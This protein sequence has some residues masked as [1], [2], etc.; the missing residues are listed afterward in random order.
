MS[1]RR[2]FV[3][4]A[5]LVVTL[6]LGVTARRNV[7]ERPRKPLDKGVPTVEDFD[8]VIA[9]LECAAIHPKQ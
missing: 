4:L 9:L 7:A 6:G 8:R 1:K 5:T 3:L 2:R